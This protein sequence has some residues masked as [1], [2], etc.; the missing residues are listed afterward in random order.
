MV[1]VRTELMRRL[2]SATDAELADLLRDR[3]DLAVPPPSS[4]AAL[5][6]RALTPA[7]VRRALAHL[8]APELR[9]AETLAIGRLAARPEELARALASTV[10]DAADLIDELRRLALV[11]GE[12]L[13]PA[14][15][16]ALRDTPWHESTLGLGPPA[17]QVAQAALVPTT[18]AALSA[19]L[20]DAPATA[21]AMVEALARGPA[22]GAH[23]EDD[24]P[25]AVSWL[26]ERHVLA[27][28]S[29]TQVVLPREVGLAVRAPRIAAAAHA[30]PPLG[31]GHVRTP[32]LV[33]AEALE[34]AGA[35]LRLVDGL[36]SLWSREPAT[37]LRSGG[38][39]VRDLRAAA[40]ATA[41]GGH[42]PEI[43]EVAFAA[44]LAD[45]AGL[46]GIHAGAEADVWAPTTRADT[47]R[48]ARPGEQWSQLVHAW[49]DQHQVSWLVGTPGRGAV[50]AA[51]T[52][53][54]E[55]GWAPALRR[56]VLSALGA[57]PAGEAPPL[58]ALTA[59]VA[60][61]APRSAPPAATIAAVCEEARRL[62]LL[63]AGTL[64]EL[65]R[66]VL[67]EEDLPGVWERIAPAPVDELFIQGDLTGVVPGPPSRDLADLV[68]LAATIESHGHGLTAR[69]T[70]ESV[71]RALEHGL[72]GAELLDRLRRHSPTP[73]PQALEYLVQD[74]ARRHG[75]LRVGAAGSYL[76][77]EG[78]DLAALAAD[79]RL[80]LRLLAPTVAVSTLEPDTLLRIL[81]ELGA[82]AVAE[83]P[84][85]EVISLTGPGVR[86]ERSRRRAE[87]APQVPAELVVARLREGDAREEEVLAGR[88]PA[89][90]D[91]AAAGQLEL[92]R[93]AAAHGRRVRISVAADRGRIDERVVRVL[94]VDA[95]RIRLLDTDRDAEIVLAVHRLM[96]VEA[97]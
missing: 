82:P 17:A 77:A 15:A 12:E 90:G 89:G 69:F 21:R 74:A 57:W 72:T 19:V 29:P 50:R 58:A 78:P 14:A 32:A 95:G 83:A 94:S 92:L 73:L 35:L 65:G 60:W 59:H 84:S 76:R 66:A 80:G 27:R 2:R 36:L 13:V 11:V 86:A 68:D 24:P 23:P 30:E 25:E 22:T 39:G 5:A 63:A 47:W 52:P 64:T 41:D 46:L 45:G 6:A 44:Q 87:P 51:L 67:A 91:G 34:S 49:L 7:S 75:A 16:D 31:A 53:E 96:R 61:Y 70:A 33:T 56:R 8:R 55:R 81:R 37:V 88:G 85:G 4:T 97:V 38:L 3:R 18:P 48:R 71:G 42:M 10:A 79:A 40:T 28:I 43:G 26:L 9:A 54:V 93:A 62:G 1:G 20:A